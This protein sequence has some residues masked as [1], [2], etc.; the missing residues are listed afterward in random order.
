MDPD[1]GALATAAYVLRLVRDSRTVSF[2]KV[3]TSVEDRFGTAV[4]VLAPAVSLLFLL[5]LLE[6]R[7]KSDSFEYTGP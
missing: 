6:Y 2:T 4:T 5:G 1:R 7:P 3:Q